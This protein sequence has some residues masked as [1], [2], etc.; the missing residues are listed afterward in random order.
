MA[1]PSLPPPLFGA[2]SGGE[3][4]LLGEGGNC[5]MWELEKKCSLSFLR[6]R[7]VLKFF[8]TSTPYNIIDS[9]S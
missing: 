2:Q 6:L 1:T 9:C 5:R 3:K 4:Y 7:R 8:S